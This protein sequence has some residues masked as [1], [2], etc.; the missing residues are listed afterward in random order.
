VQFSATSHTPAEG[1]QTVLLAANP[2]AGHVAELPVQ[3]SATS[4]TPADARHTVPAASFTSA[5]QLTDEPSQVSA[6]SQVPAA[7][8]HTVP[9]ATLESAGQGAVVPLHVS[10]TSQ[11]PAAARHTVPAA[12][13]TPPAQLPAALHFSPLVH[14][15]PSLHAKLSCVASATQNPALHF[16]QLVPQSALTT[17]AAPIT[18]SLT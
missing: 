13:A 11:T 10:A 8:R 18:A 5:G 1:R 14:A 9:A 12:T 16:W 6:T 2:S 15:L 7:A 3:V 4:Q 17:Q